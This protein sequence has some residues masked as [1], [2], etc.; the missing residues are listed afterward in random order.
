[1]SAVERAVRQSRSREPLDAAQPVDTV[2]ASCEREHQ[3][4]DVLRAGD[5]GAPTDAQNLDAGSGASRDIDVAEHGAVFVND[6]E[7]GRASKLF[8]SHGKGLDDQCARGRKI[9]TQ[10][11]LGRHQADLAGIE[12]SHAR[13]ELIA[14]ERKIRLIGLKAAKAARRSSDVVGSST[15]PIRRVQGSSSTTIIGGFEVNE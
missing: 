8:F 15:T 2:D 1:M 9:G 4:K 11:G 3:R 13:S 7:L 10:L 14:P 6:L 5:I 12:P